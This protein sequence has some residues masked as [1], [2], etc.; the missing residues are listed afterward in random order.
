MVYETFGTK[1]TEWAG[2]TYADIVELAQS[3]GSAL[4]VPVGSIEQHGHHLPVATDT[5]LADAVAHAGAE[6]AATDVPVLVT[7]PIWSGYSPHQL[8]FGGTLTVQH[9]HLLHTLEDIVG[10]ALQNGFNAVLLLNGHGGNTPLINSATSTIGVEHSNVDILGATYFEL[11]APFIDDIRESDIGGSAHGG[12]FE[13]SLMLYLRRD[14]VREDCIEGEPLVEPYTHGLK[15]MFASGPLGV[16]R[17]FDEY[18]DNGAIGE[19][20]LATAEK[21]EE[22]YTQLGDELAGILQELHTETYG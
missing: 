19:P 9:E 12:E 5:I 2:K 7:P 13:T 1:S 17:S 8:S 15:D 11:A 22:L 14:L 18:S 10:T 16:Y 3:E 20:E 4:V 6:R 21:G